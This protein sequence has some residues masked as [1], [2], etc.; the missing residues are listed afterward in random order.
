VSE[1]VGVP[2]PRPVTRP[3]RLRT[4]SGLRRMVAETAVEP[5]QLVFPVFIR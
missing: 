5:A 2:V 1:P 4:T 3:R